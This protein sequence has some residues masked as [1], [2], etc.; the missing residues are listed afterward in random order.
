MFKSTNKFFLHNL[1]YSIITILARYPISLF[2]LTMVIGF[3]SVNAI[4]IPSDIYA[5]HSQLFKVIVSVTNNG[6]NGEHGVLHVFIDGGVTSKWLNNLYFPSKQT[7]SKTFE[8]L[9]SDIPVDT[10]F[11]VEVIYGDDIFKRTSGTNTESNA[12][13]T[14]HIDIP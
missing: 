7:V 10:T 13:E 3:F 2:T 11:N 8:F 1:S 5:Q 4:G 9:S 12:P 14:V 6:N